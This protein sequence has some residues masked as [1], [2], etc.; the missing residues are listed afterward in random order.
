MAEKAAGMT[1]DDDT[2]EVLAGAWEPQGIE[3]W[4]LELDLLYVE[5]DGD[6]DPFRF[7]VLRPEQRTGQAVAFLAAAPPFGHLPG[8][9]IEGGPHVHAAD[10]L[11]VG[12][13]EPA[14]GFA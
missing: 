2:H 5:R 4:G 13:Q 1:Y 14:D 8:G 6:L 3:G 10:Q 7:F 11:G 12:G 9:L